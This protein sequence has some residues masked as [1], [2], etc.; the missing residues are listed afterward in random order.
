MYRATSG[1]YRKRG[2]RSKGRKRETTIHTLINN[3]FSMEQNVQNWSQTTNNIFIAVLIFSIGSIAA[4]IL[5]LLGSF[6]FVR[7]LVWIVEIGVIAGY[8][9]YILR[10]GDLRTMVE[11]KERA[12]IGQIRTAAI[13][14]I[15]TAIL[16][17]FSLSGW[18]AG[19]I[20]FAAFVIMLV[21]FNTLKKSTTMPEKARS[22]FN[23]L[24]IAMLLNIIAVG[25]MTILSWIPLVGIVMATIAGILGIIGFIMVITGWAAVKNS[26]APIA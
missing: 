4:G 22:G 15:V 23:Q 2:E 1:N 21:G 16:G 9:L 3:G 17:L 14:T 25:L 13:L 20:N 7:V 19:I 5:S 18:I 24:F 12:A 8:V 10:L 26:P 11:E 6:S